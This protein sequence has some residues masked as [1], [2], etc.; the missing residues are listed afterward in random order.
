VLLLFAFFMATTTIA[1]SD[2]VK[3]GGMAGGV[4]AV[5]GLGL[6]TVLAGHPERVAGWTGRL[7]RVLPG[8]LGHTA[9]GLV[10]RFTEGLV[11][12]RQPGPLLVASVLSV[13]LW[14]SI[15]IG[16]W[17]TS[18]AF[19]IN[20]P[21]SGTFLV[22]MFLVV[23]VAVPTPAGVGAFHWAYR[24]AVTTFFGAGEGE[25]SAAAIV[26][27]AVSFV[28]VSLLGLIFMAQDGLTLAGLRRMRSTAEAAERTP[29]GVTQPRV[30]ETP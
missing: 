12:M 16:V 10:H 5:A 25:A 24:V 4:L 17:L 26:L 11:V 8:R 23:G 29:A 13:L 9:A 22:L 27:H 18:R 3:L 6:M 28:P 30:E 19:A 7:L 21:V 14:I 20:Y 2:D 1:V 15:A